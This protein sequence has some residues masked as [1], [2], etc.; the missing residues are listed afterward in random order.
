MTTKKRKTLREQRATYSFDVALPALL[1]IAAVQQRLGQIFPEAF[2]DRGIL[3]G[4]MAARVVFVFL[5]GG[6]L[7]GHA[8]YL[9]PS[10]IYFFTEEQARATDE[11]SRR[12]WLA[13]ASRPG[14]RPAGK[15]WYADTSREPIR[16]DLMRNQLLRLGILRKREGVATTAS[17]PINF[18]TG[19]FAA[20]FD[21]ALTGAEL[22]TAIERWRET[23]LNAATLQRMALRAGG[24]TAR[25][26]DV[27]IEL[28]D[29]ERLRI[30]GGDSARI[31]K[32]LIEQFA[33][34]HLDEPSVLWLSASDKKAYPQ[35]V[36]RAATVG[37]HLDLNAELPDLILVDLGAQTRFYFCEVVATDGAV[38]EDRKQALLALVR[39]SKI[40]ADAVR[41][42]TAFEDREAPPFRKNV[43]QLAVDSWVWFRTE[44]ELLVVLTTS[45]IEALGG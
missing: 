37:L 9:R 17:T 24:A 6:F 23:H 41:F 7:E 27:F 13:V 45:A 3:V 14:H 18:L 29:G 4:T 15:R 38:T 40:P 1:P 26:G 19:D 21:P 28:P 22:D 5:Y 34:K 2:P 10:H 31:V 42:V 20:L 30:A 11:A 25:E 36:A 32:G 43:S 33:A 39:G 44:P 8:R 35:Y 16:D 12:D